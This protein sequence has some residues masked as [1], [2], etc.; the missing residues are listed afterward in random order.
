LTG[1]CHTSLIGELSPVKE[2]YNMT[3]TLTPREAALIKDSIERNKADFQHHADLFNDGWD[4][5]TIQEL[6]TLAKRF[7]S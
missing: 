7:N 6:E 4:Q 3:I 2:H 5:N 1:L